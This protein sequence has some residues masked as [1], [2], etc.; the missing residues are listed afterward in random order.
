MGYTLENEGSQEDGFVDDLVP[1]IAQA[2]ASGALVSR[3]Q[4][5]AEIDLMLR[6]VREFWQM[7]PDEIGRLC[8]AMSARC[9]ELCVHLHRLETQRQ[10]KQIRTQQVERLIEE[11][12]RQWAIASRMVELRRQ[13]IE[14][15]R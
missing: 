1:T 2:L 11:M 8:Q 10:W 12:K 4:V 7:E 6:T 3:E 14:L 9:T 15:S 5:E 13:D